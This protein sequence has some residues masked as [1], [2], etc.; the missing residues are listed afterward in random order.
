[1]KKHLLKI[2]LA[3]VLA[4]SLFFSWVKV[5]ELEKLAQEAAKYHKLFKETQRTN[6]EL[7][8]QLAECHQDTVR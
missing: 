1:M 2:I 6:E 7:S 5:Q 8:A 3:I 4:Y